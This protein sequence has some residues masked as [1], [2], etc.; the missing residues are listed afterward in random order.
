MRISFFLFFSIVSIAAAA[1][2]KKKED[3]ALLTNLQVHVTFL[4]SDKLEGRRTGTEGEKA[5]VYPIHRK[6]SQ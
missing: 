5:A 2:K 6:L 4:A 1:Q 3:A